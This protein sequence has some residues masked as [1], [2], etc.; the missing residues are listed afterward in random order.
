MLALDKMPRGR[1]IDSGGTWYHGISKLFLIVTHHSFTAE[2]KMDNFDVGLD[3]NQHSA[4]YTYEDWEFLPSDTHT[5][6]NKQ[7]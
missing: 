3:T 6:F 2:Y 4:S 7:E 5:N 1:P